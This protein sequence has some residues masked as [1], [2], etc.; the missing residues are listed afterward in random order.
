MLS[1]ISDLRMEKGCLKYK[2]YKDVEIEDLI[3]LEMEWNSK[4][5]IEQHFQSKNFRIILGAMKTLLS[6][7]NIKIRDVSSFQEEGFV[8]SLESRMKY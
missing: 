7:P 3:L 4:D 1:I 8:R 2:I 6:M 5:A